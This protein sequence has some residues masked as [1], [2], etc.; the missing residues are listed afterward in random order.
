[1][2]EPLRPHPPSLICEP[3]RT[4]RGGRRLLCSIDIITRCFFFYHP[5]FLP[6]RPPL[7]PST[8]PSIPPSSIPNTPNCDK[9]NIHHITHLRTAHSF[10][11]SC[12]HA[13]MQCL[14]GLGWWGQYDRTQFHDSKGSGRSYFDLLTI[15]QCSNHSYLDDFGR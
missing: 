11:H 10:L 6:D 12:M 3:L 9:H 1:M 2:N 8:Q 5:L 7:P 4:K 15:T 14:R 13:C